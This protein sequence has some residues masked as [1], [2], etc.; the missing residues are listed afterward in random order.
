[1]AAPGLR[2]KVVSKDDLKR[3]MR[4][5]KEALTQSS[6]KITS[7]Y[8]K[9]NSI[10]QLMC[11][12]CALH[13]KGEALWAPHILGKAHKQNLQ[14]LQDT[15]KAR[16]TQGESS[17]TKRGND[18]FEAHKDGPHTGENSSVYVNR[19][20]PP[21]KRA[22]ESSL[23]S[24][25]SSDDGMDVGDSSSVPKQ[26]AAEKSGSVLPSDFFEVPMAPPKQVLPNS[27]SVPKSQCPEKKRKAA[28][29]LPEGFFDDPVLDAK[30]RNVEYKDPI[31]EEWEKFQ[32]EIAE[33]TNVS[34]AIMAEDVEESKVER[35]IEEI[36]EQIHNWQRV[37]QLQQRK[38]ELMKNEANAMEQN[39]NSDS[40]I[41]EQQ[42]DEYLS[43][44]AKGVW[45]Q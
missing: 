36:D 43:W 21:H 1:M 44:R 39:D 27:T 9:Y 37:E 20:S 38:E 24:G 32:K 3:L 45:K 13:I 33:E 15:L 23:I 41:D 40:D 7:P 31:E 5:R 42:F 8:A 25:N 16:Q 34:E 2:K 19:E 11:T 35:D 10:G 4:E 14:D 26:S 18:R 6:K 12:V 29:A 28:E 22:K 30:A 17:T